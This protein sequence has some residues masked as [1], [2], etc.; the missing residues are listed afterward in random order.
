M[1][2]PGLLPSHYAPAT[3][4]VLTDTPIKFCNDE[5]VAIILRKPTESA[6]RGSVFVL[7][8]DGDLRSAAAMLY[9]TLRL[10]DGMHF[11][12]IVAERF[13]GKGIGVAAN[14][15]MTRAAAKKS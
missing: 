9:Q 6:Y 10:V 1:A 8:P 11:D 13:P 15:R 2:S 3:P 12:L 7:S 14:D 5:H 4:M